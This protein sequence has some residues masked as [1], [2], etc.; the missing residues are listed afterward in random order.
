MLGGREEG[1]GCWAEPLVNPSAHGSQ[2]W[3]ECG[4][5]LSEQ[6]SAAQEG[7]L[8]P[9]GREEGNKAELAAGWECE[10]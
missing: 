10:C 9:E 6:A 8:P 5:R 1:Y 7:V 2:K 3:K 4:E